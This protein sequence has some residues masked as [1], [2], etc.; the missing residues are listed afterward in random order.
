LLAE[1]APEQAAAVAELLR[2]L[3]ASTPLPHAVRFARGE[4]LFF[5]GQLAPAGAIFRDLLQAVPERTGEIRDALLRFD[6]DSPE[7]AEA[8][9]LLATL[10]LDRRDYKGALAE[11]TRG[12]LGGPLLDRVITKYEEILTQASDDLEARAGFI[13]ALL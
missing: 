6:R 8:R 13:E 12:G 5:A 9:V 11:L 4:A 3:E 1:A 10:C 7:A 2:G